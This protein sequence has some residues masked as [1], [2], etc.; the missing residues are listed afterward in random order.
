MS[1]SLGI[2]ESSTAFPVRPLRRRGRPFDK[3]RA[4]SRYSRRDA[5]ATLN[6]KRLALCISILSGIAGFGTKRIRGRSWYQTR[7]LSEPLVFPEGAERC[8]SGRLLYCAATNRNR[9]GRGPASGAG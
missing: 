6:Q 9:L 5:G 8:D 4:G 3:L 1:K 2:F 7:G